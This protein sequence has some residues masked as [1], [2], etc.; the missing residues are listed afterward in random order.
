MVPC[1]TAGEVW[2]K[3][4]SALACTIDFCSHPTRTS[5]KKDPPRHDSLWASPSARDNPVYHVRQ[6]GT[7]CDYQVVRTLITRAN[8]PHVQSD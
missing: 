2:H 7:E 3:S 6:T 4:T 1:A 5:L 8:G